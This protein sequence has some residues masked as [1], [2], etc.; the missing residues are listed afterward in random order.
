MN[1][2][3]QLLDKIYNACGAIAALNLFM[4]LMAV[5]VQVLSRWSGVQ[6]PGATD[7]AGYFMASASFMAFA[8]TLSHGGHIRVS[9][10]LSKLKSRSRL[11]AERWCFGIASA[12]SCYF[13]YYAVK[14]AIWSYK[15]NDISQGLDAT[16]LWIP[17]MSMAIGAIVLA[18]SF[19][20]NFLRIVFGGLE[21]LDNG[22]ATSLDAE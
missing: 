18:I 9:V 16:P 14:G 4:I 22:S 12:I 7:Y 10:V 17:Q 3:R 1:G 19:V 5:V 2:I 8:Y 15:L 21:A 6:V 11:W 13:A 20:D